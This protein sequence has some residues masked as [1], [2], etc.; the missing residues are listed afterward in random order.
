M[1]NELADKTSDLALPHPATPRLWWQDAVVYEIYLRSFADSN[2]DGVGDLGGLRSHLSYLADLGVDALWVTPFYP[3]P[4]A[5]HGYDISDYC[6]VDPLFGSLTELDELLVE[7][8]ALGLRVII[9]LV[10]NHTSNAHPW[11]S[12][13]LRDPRSVERDFYVFRPPGPEGGPPNNWQSVFGGPAWT[14]DPASGEYYL[15]LFDS[16]QPDLNWRNPLV[17]QAWEKILR[18]WLDR[19]VDGF[20]IDV[21]HG[22][23]KHP[24]LADNADP[25]PSAP[26]TEHLRSISALNCW[27]QPE[28]LDVYRRWRAIC[29]SYDERMMVGEVF[30]FDM[31]RVA[32]Y[33]GADL[34]HQAFNFLI[35]AIPFDAAAWQRTVRFALDRFVR[36]GAAPTWVLS[37]HDLVRHVTR[38]SG[39]PGGRR[40]G[41]AFTTAL[42]AL[43]G[44]SYLY[45]GEELGLEQAEVPVE[46]R[47]DPIWR[48]SGGRVAGR[49]GCRSPMPWTGDPPGYGFTRATPWL[50]FGAD[51]ADRNVARQ[52]EL[53]RSTLAF[54]RRALAARRGLRTQL[55]DDVHW[56]AAPPECCSFARFFHDGR[57]LVVVL[58]TGS[59]DAEVGLH[60]AP[61]EV[62]LAS[63]DTVQLRGGSVLVPAESTAWVI[64]DD[65]AAAS[66]R[67]ADQVNPP[68]PETS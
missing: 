54:Y 64:V 47:Q 23:Y 44:A 43:P 24:E 30:L 61:R 17:H 14:L 18:F 1:V 55:H 8:H 42:L 28:V 68:G 41:L 59:R 25:G 13:A 57:A 60:G 52:D 51:A 19:G 39:G 53:D 46:A 36:E 65:L 34:L 10:P 26:G 40:R 56:L 20:R 38:Y 6:D 32:S 58:N 16:A 9:D 48:R 50:P 27:D 3:S 49:D 45:Q 62:V 2:D 22:L 12:A 5:D 66:I 15:H 21:A 37:N 63:A 4:M 7:A 33:T 29:D 31:D 11:F 67:D 35:M